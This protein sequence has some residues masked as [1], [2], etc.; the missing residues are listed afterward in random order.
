MI[1]REIV[2]SYLEQKIYK[3]SLEHFVIPDSIKGKVSNAFR[4]MAENPQKL[5]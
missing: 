1:L 4:D 3:M 5:N 2:D